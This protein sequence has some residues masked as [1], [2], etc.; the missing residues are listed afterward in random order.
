MILWLTAW[1]CAGQLT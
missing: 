1:P